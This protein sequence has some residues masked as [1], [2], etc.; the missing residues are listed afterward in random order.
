VFTET[1]FQT[2]ERSSTVDDGG[3]VGTAYLVFAYL[4]AL[5][6][7]IVGLGFGVYGWAQDSKHGVIVTVLSVI[8]MFVGCMM[9]AA[10]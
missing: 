6:L 9:M 3:E 2:F 10:A 4:F 7:P 8:N 5:L 1:D